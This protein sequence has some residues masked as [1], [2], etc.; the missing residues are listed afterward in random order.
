M[1]APLADLR[2]D[3][4]QLARTENVQV[5]HL[6][7]YT[8]LDQPGP[9]V[10]ES[11]WF[12]LGGGNG[13]ALDGRL[14]VYYDGAS[15]PAIDIDFGT[16]LATH[17]GASGSMSCEHVHVE[18][19]GTSDNTGVLLTYPLPFG[20]HIKITYY[21]PSTSQAAQLFAMATY[22]F[23]ATDQAAGQ[24]LRCAGA[25]FLDQVLTR[26]AGDVTT[27]AAITNGPGWVVWHSM[28]GGIDA[29]TIS[30]GSANSDSWMERNIALYVDGETTPSIESSGTEDWF[31]SAWYFEGRKDSGLSVHSYIGTDKPTNQP[32]TVGMATDLWSKWGGVPFQSSCKVEVLTEP[33]CVTGDKVCWAI[34]YY[35]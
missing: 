23:T 33:L 29:A 3:R 21:N 12:A 30:P 15:V 7:E 5:G 32:H 35:Q 25:R 26:Q 11:L 18:I 14:R 1:A 10:V 34:L 8:V 19:D 27:L 22:S 24:R 31:D 28:V 9:G 2:T 13:P 17:W 20:T 6:A 16:L 4:L